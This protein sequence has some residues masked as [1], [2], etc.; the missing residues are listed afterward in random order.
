MCHGL[1]RLGRLRRRRMTLAHPFLLNEQTL[2]AFH[3]NAPALVSAKLLGRF[4]LAIGDRADETP[5]VV[6]ASDTLRKASVRPARETDAE[7]VGWCEGEVR[8]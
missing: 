1:N 2:G 6:A 4:C 7:G 5:K 3:R 8:P